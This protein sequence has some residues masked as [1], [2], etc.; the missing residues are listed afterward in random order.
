[1]I[2]WS[3]TDYGRRPT[4]VLGRA[5]D[6]AHSARRQARPERCRL[7]VRVNVRAAWYLRGVQAA[8]DRVRGVQDPLNDCSRACS[9]G[10]ASPRRLA[11]PHQKNCETRERRKTVSTWAKSTASAFSAATGSW[12]ASRKDWIHIHPGAERLAGAGEDEDVGGWP[13]RLGQGHVG[14][15]VADRDG[16]RCGRCGCSP[17]G[18][19]R[20]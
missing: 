6:D 5:V 20:R 2:S 17:L 15:G 8:D 10:A 18:S 11:A 14:R 16:W 4:T 1:M 13:R 7:P 12:S 9:L 19:R 3:S